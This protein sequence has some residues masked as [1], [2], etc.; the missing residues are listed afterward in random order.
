[1][2]PENVCARFDC[3][4]REF[5]FSIDA[6][7]AEESGV[8]YVETVGCHDYFDVFGG[9]ETIKLVKEFEH[10]AL[11]FGIAAGTT[12]DTGGTDAVDFVHE[13]DARS[14]FAR[15]DEEL[16]NHSAAFADVFLD[17][18]GAGDANEFAVGVVCYCSC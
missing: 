11:D 10:R 12:F 9:F 18:L 3:G 8:Q 1:M 14:V 13:D 5:Y 6:A 16:T 15:H 4:G 7:G 17:E 2:D